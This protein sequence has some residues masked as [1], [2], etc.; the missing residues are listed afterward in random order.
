MRGFGNILEEWIPFVFS[1]LCMALVFAS[2]NFNLAGE[3]SF[4]IGAL[5]AMILSTTL[6][7]PPVFFW[8]LLL[9]VSGFC[10]SIVVGFPGYIKNK[11]GANEIVSSIMLIFIIYHF[12]TYVLVNFFKDPGARA[13]ASL[14]FN[15]IYR[16]PV[17]IPKTNV[18][19]GLIFAIIAFIFV[20]IFYSHTQ[21]GYEIRITGENKNFAKVLGINTARTGL[22]AQLIGGALTGMG[23]SIHML[24]MYPY[25]ES[26][27]FN[28]GWDGVIVATLARHNPKYVPLAALFLAYL[29]A[30]SKIMARRS[31]VPAEIIFIAQGI[32][33]LLIV[34]KSLMAK[35]EY[36]LLLKSIDNGQE[37]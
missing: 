25:F 34:A 8:L 37:R 3:G 33:I 18:H 31:D 36:R 30:G 5:L 10:G 21:S 16:L 14:P 19:L 27:L 7:I 1:G 35:Y 6:N 4:Y 17:L 28:Y 24:G 22:S 29:R 26:K 32:I 20:Y 9:L 15:P 2:N 12:G 11:T 23:G 13:M